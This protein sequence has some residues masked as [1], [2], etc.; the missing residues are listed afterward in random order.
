M[1]VSPMG[2]AEQQREEERLYREYL[3]EIL[4]AIQRGDELVRVAG[5]IAERSGIDAR[6]SY[7]WVQYT[8]QNLDRSRKRLAVGGLVPL[9]IGILTIVVEAVGVALGHIAATAPGV[10]A[11]AAAA[12]ALIVVGMLLLRDLRGRSVA[13]VRGAEET[14]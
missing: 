13:R 10:I 5:G 7:R 4:E 14:D 3:P 1:Y 6:T 8:E 2:V 9:W 12:V 11:V